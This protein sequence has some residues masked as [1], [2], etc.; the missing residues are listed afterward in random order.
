[1]FYYYGIE[2]FNVIGII[3]LNNNIFLLWDSLKKNVFLIYEILWMNSHY[4]FY[5][6]SKCGVAFYTELIDSLNNFKLKIPE[7]YEFLTTYSQEMFVYG[8][9]LINLISVKNKCNVDSLFD[10]IVYV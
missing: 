10:L 7:E 3:F 8:T 1:M 2:A 9:Q 6:N 4:L 5:Q